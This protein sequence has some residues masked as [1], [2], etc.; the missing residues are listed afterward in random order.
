MSRSYASL[1]LEKQWLRLRIRPAPSR[2]EGSVQIDP[3]S[4]SKEQHMSAIPKARRAWSLALIVVVL[5]VVGATAWVTR[6]ER[7]AVRGSS[8]AGVIIE[9]NRYTGTL[10]ATKWHHNAQFELILRELELPP[11]PSHQTAPRRP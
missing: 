2:L 11:N 10:K 7:L 4:T 1:W 6:Y 8:G 5:G 3:S 9:R